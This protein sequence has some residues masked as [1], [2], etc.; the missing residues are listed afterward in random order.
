MSTNRRYPSLVGPIIVIGFGVLLL[1]SN[2][3]MIQWS[4][5]D[6][7]AKLWPLLLVA[8]GLDLLIG[9]RSPLGNL[10]VAFLMIAMLVAA[11]G[12]SIRRGPAAARRPTTT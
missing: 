8:A 12:G 5:W 2:L 11:S 4:V 10:L 6:A 7:I 3:G 9:R 1:M